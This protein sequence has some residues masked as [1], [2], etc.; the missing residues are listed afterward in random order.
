MMNRPAYHRRGFTLVEAIIVIAIT[1]VIAAMVAIFI[2]TP[3]QAYFDSAARAELTDVADTALR[4]MARDLRL[5]LPNS[6]RVNGQYLELLLTSDGGRYLA[7]EDNPTGSN[8][9]I[10][11]FNDST[12]LTFDIVGPVPPIS[13]GNDQIV[14]YNLGPNQVPADA[15]DCTAQC[16]RAQV[17]GI[18][19]STVTLTANP[20]AAQTPP[21]RSPSQRFQIVTTPVTYACVNNTLV[22]YA[23]YAIQKG[24][25]TDVTASPL[26]DAPSQAVLAR[27]QALNCTFSNASMANTR[28]GLV[29]LGISM[30]GTGNAGIVQLFHQ[31]HVDNTP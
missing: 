24:Q 30:T 10:L 13:A 6:I 12:K 8:P 4:R 27:S 28:S 20:F 3:V 19:G 29:G 26:K 9:P 5:A 2:R 7:E 1:G 23:G 17:A 14:V 25:P 18:A 21:M 15:Y 31:V 22:R 16:N 11:D